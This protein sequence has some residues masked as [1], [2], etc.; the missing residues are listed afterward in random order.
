MS[1]Y[2]RL[3]RRLGYDTTTTVEETRPTKRYT[4]I[5][6]NDEASTV[7]AHGYK[8]KGAFATFYVY[9]DSYVW[10]FHDYRLSPLSTDVRVLDSIKE[11]ESEATGETTFRA[12]VDRADEGVLSKEIHNGLP[13]EQVVA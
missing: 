8:T 3:R 10:T 11:I 5:H 4:V 6:L 7:E 9:T 1:L 13:A 2:H 12:T